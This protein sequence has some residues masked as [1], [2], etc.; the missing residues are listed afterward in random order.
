MLRLLAQCH[1]AAKAPSRF[2]SFLITAPRQLSAPFP[3]RAW[4]GIP[5]EKNELMTMIFLAWNVF[6]VD[7][8]DAQSSLFRRAI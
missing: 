6:S 7:F 2:K 3:A 8:A 4:R 5:A 1:A